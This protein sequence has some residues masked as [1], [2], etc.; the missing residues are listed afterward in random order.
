MAA[1]DVAPG[2]AAIRG[3]TSSRTYDE[4]LGKNTVPPKAQKSDPTQPRS[5]KP[6]ALQPLTPAKVKER[7]EKAQA[8]QSERVQD[9]W[10]NS[11]F[12]ENHQWL[13]FNRSSNRIDSIPRES[14]ERVQA[15]ITFTRRRR[16]SA[17]L[18]RSQ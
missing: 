13:W 5:R 9:Y 11:A 14:E 16:S 4:M 18:V 15:T 8:A 1:L 3:D 6:P 2:G 17:P 12:L 10:L 7:W